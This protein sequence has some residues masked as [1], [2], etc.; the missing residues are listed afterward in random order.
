M[1]YINSFISKYK[2]AIMSG[3]IFL[4]VAGI[5]FVCIYFYSDSDSKTDLKTDINNSERIEQITTSD[6]VLAGDSTI[7]VVCNSET[8][9]KAMFMALFDF[10]VLSERIIVTPLDMNV[11]DGTRTFDQSYSYGGINEL[12]S[13]IERVRDCHIDR[14]A[15]IDKNGMGELTNILGKI[16][17]YVEEEYTY[18]SSDKSYSVDTGYNNLE[19]AMLYGYLKSVCE[20]SDGNERIAD[21]LCIIVNYYLSD[22]KAEQAQ[23]LFEKLCNCINTDITIADYFTCSSDIEYLLTHNTE[24][25]VYN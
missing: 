23:E 8:I 14:Y 25:F 15:I 12:V 17:L 3:V 21:L 2:Y 6:N 10:H 19:S 13:T 16:N 9:G 1:N 18:L 22:I 24:C 5:V 7:L 11:S 20:Q 4:L